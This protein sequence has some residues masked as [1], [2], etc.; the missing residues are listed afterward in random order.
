MSI[1]GPRARS[2]AT[3][4][5]GVGIALGVA[6]LLSPIRGSLFA[7]SAVATASTAEAL[8]VGPDSVDTSAGE[9]IGRQGLSN[10]S[11]NL[12]PAPSIDPALDAVAR[13]Q[14]RAAIAGSADSSNLG[15]RLLH[16]APDVLVRIGVVSTAEL[17]AR[18]NLFSLSGPAEVDAVSHSGPAEVDA[19]S[20][21]G[22]AEV[23][24]VGSAGGEALIQAPD[25][26]DTYVAEV[27]AVA[28]R[29]PRAADAPDELTAL[30]G[31]PPQTEAELN[32]AAARRWLDIENRDRQ[33]NNFPTELLARRDP[34]LDREAENTMRRKLGEPVLPAVVDPTGIVALDNKVHFTAYL[35][36]PNCEP[37]V[38]VPDRVVDLL[39]QPTVE[40]V[41]ARSVS[42]PH[43][44]D[45]DYY[46]NKLTWAVQLP[47]LPHYWNSYRLFGIATRVHTDQEVVEH[48]DAVRAATESVAAGGSDVWDPRE[49]K[50]DIVVLAYDPWPT[51]WHRR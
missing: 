17:D 13:D 31:T 10:Y 51:D 44:L 40:S 30:Y 3:V 2:A 19:V 37:F 15:P 9:R 8:T 21:S 16:P 22:P 39:R 5:A 50:V 25:S 18:A 38:T 4:A 35:C 32:A 29:D 33:A 43:L 48:R 42:M 41:A 14:L 11:R 23:D 46:N 47:T 34:V 45:F 49:Y 36:S 27:A 6:A 28:W 20:H 7:A 26:S 24:A 1:P 12:N